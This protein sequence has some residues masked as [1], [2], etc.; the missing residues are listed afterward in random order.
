M[1]WGHGG[2]NREIQYPC[3]LQHENALGALN[4]TEWGQWGHIKESDEVHLLFYW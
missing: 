2:K 3:G 4:G 1:Q